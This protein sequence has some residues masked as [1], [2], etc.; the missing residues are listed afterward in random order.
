MQVSLKT[1]EQK[2]REECEPN[3]SRSIKINVNAIYVLDI[4]FLR[5]TQKNMFEN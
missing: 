5:E 4:E 2:K 1:N 3:L